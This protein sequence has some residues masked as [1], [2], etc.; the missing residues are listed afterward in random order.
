MYQGKIVEEG[1]PDE[2]IR[3]LG[4]DTTR[5]LLQGPDRMKKVRTLM[6]RRRQAYEECADIRVAVSGKKP[7]EIA[8][9]ILCAVE[10]KKTDREQK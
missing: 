8:A 10:N 6:A 1:T 9:E 3:R 4:K 5:P 2:V 7:A